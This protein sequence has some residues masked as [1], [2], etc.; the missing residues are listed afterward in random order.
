M[1]R[2]ALV[3]KGSTLVL[4][5]DT[6]GFRLLKPKTLDALNAFGW[7]EVHSWLHSPGRFSFRFYEEKYIPPTMPQFER[8]M[9]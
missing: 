4:E 6:L 2:S 1:T 5:V 8:C 3:Q 9:R 7:G